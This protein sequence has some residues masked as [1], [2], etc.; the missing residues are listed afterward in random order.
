MEPEWEDKT[1]PVVMN[2]A[3]KNLMLFANFCFLLRESLLN[4]QPK[5]ERRA[6]DWVLPEKPVASRFTINFIMADKREGW[7]GSRN[8]LVSEV[9]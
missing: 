2:I 5:A 3:G 9:T 6:A 8:Q 1:L 4:S 7:T